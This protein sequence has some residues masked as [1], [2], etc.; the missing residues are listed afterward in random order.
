MAQAAWSGA[1][2]SDVDA[3][4]REFI[5]LQTEVIAT[6]SDVI[7]GTAATMA[8]LRGRGIRIGSTTG[9]AREM[10]QSLIPEAARNGFDPDCTVCADDVPQGRPAP[11]MA[12]RAAM[13]MNSYPV[14]ACVKVG[15]TL[16]DI[17]EGLNAGMWTVGVT[18]TGNEIGLS[19][20]EANALPAGE[21]R[22]GLEQAAARLHSAGAHYVIEGI[23]ALPVVV[24]E[25]EARLS[26]GERP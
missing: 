24:D 16:A 17:A 18:R 6:H 5:P 23:A 25:I 15:D 13:E 3:L 9:Y 19:E 1:G 7:P 22:R 11:W 20:Q 12:L 14:S 21:L 8:Q 10:M 2:G 4:Y 26:R